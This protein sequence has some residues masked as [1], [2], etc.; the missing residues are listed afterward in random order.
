MVATLT[1]ADRQSPGV[2]EHRYLRWAGVLGL[3]PLAMFIAA[4]FMS[5]FPYP[6][7]NVDGHEY[8]DYMLH[9]RTGELQGIL[10]SG[11]ALILLT[12]MMLLA[13][14]YMKR[15]GRLTVSGLTMITTMVISAALYMM[16]SG[17]FAAATLYI[18]GYPTFGSAPQ[19]YR[20]MTFVWDAVNVI[21][22]L[23]VLVR[24]LA[25]AALAVANRSFPLLPRALGGWGAAAV[26][27]VNLVCVGALFVPTGPWGPSGVYIT[28]IAE[29]AAEGWILVTAV[30]LL[31]ATRRMA[32]GSSDPLPQVTD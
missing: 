29:G 5:R 17:L 21:Y 18:R 3:F 10:A 11:Y 22:W 31:R 12:V 27:A 20:L 6:G 13:I 25:W 19:D 24:G 28:F 4:M 1:A 32:A 30:Y 15:A 26:A 16:A 2:H 8:V 23:G 9:N 7:N 14:V